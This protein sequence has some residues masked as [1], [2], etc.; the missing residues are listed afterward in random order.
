LKLGKILLAVGLV[1]V[2]WALVGVPMVARAAEKSPADLLAEAAKLCEA[3]NYEGAL[4]RLQKIDRAAL[5]FFDK[6][7]YDALLEDTQKAVA[8]KAADD[9][10]FAEGKEALSKK[11]FATAIKKLSQAAESPYL[12]AD[13][14]GPAK[15]LLRLA[16]A[17]PRPSS[18]PALFST[19]PPPTSRP[20][21]PTPPARRSSRSGRWT[22]TSP[23]STALPWRTSSRA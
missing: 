22:S 23:A 11:Q 21:T 12:D 15:G 7:K 1:G 19:R 16:R 8:G 14:A 20:A 13:K 18:R 5:G 17:R 9:K 3:H 10:A 4:K 2:V 6:G